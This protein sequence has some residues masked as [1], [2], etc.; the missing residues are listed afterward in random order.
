VLVDFCPINQQFD[1]QIDDASAA[2]NKAYTDA[3]LVWRKAFAGDISI[4]SY[5]RKYAWD[6]LPVLI[7]HYMQED[8]QWYAKLPVQGVSTYAEPGDWGTY[9]LNHYVLAALAWDPD[10]DV[11]AVVKKFCA[12]RYGEFADQARSALLTLEQITR[13][14]CSIPNSSLKTADA[15]EA[16]HGRATKLVDETTKAAAK[17]TDPAIKRSLERLSLMCTY[18]QRDLEIQHLRAT[19][20]DKEKIRQKVTELQHFLQQHADDGV[21]IA[22]GQSRIFRR[23]GLDDKQGG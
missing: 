11:D 18:A 23:Y 17:A 20:A 1:H 16:D 3:L 15:I 10:C 13:N 5:Y 21:F 14:T 19:N 6:S 22:K 8:L 2:K 4:Y 12:A 7:P 9:E